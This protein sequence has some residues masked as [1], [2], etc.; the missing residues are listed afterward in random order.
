MGPIAV[1]NGETVARA[2]YACA[3]PVRHGPGI[4][5]FQRFPDGGGL[6]CIEYAFDPAGSPRLNA[7]GSENP[8]RR[9]AGR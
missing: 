3:V 9:P 1:G 2:I 6:R 8:S 5:V 7:C 4:E